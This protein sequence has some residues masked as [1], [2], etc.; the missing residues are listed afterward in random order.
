MN[1][2][3]IKKALDLLGEECLE[4]I[5]D[6]L[7]IRASFNVLVESCLSHYI[8][9]MIEELNIGNIGSIWLSRWNAGKA[10]L[11]HFSPTEEERKRKGI[12]YLQKPI[13]I[14][15]FLSRKIF[16]NYESNPE[17][18]NLIIIPVLKEF[19]IKFDFH[20]VDSEQNLN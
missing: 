20:I 4:K 12:A 2:D 16:F 7:T 9:K 14:G 6:L 13:G 17:Y 19:F 5:D 10:F 11:I 15:K 18:L 8:E 3:R 1:E